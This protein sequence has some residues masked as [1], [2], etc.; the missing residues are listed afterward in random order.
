MLLCAIG[1]GLD[2]AKGIVSKCYDI[3]VSVD[4]GQQQAVV[5]AVLVTR[6]SAAAQLP[7]LVHKAV[8]SIVALVGTKQRSGARS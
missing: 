3:A 4:L 5:R 2:P 1:G 6:Q 7:A 8:I